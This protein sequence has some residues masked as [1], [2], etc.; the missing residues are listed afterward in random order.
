MIS[1]AYTWNQALESRT[2]VDGN[3]VDYNYVL[4][5]Y[6]DETLIVVV[7]GGSNDY[8][9]PTP[10]EFHKSYYEAIHGSWGVYAPGYEQSN[11]GPSGHQSGFGSIG[12][13][14]YDDTVYNQALSKVYDDIRGTIDLSVDFA[15]A[16]QVFRMLKSVS[17]LSNYVRSF[18]PKNWGRKWLEYQYGW[19]PLVNTV[20]ESANRVVNQAV[21]PKTVKARAAQTADLVDSPFILGTN[22]QASRR[23]Y[24]SARAEISLTYE[25]P[26][27]TLNTLSQF[28]SLNPA[29]IAWELMPGSFVI[30]WLVDVGGYLRNAE[31]ALLLS[32]GFKS[33]Y[34]TETTLLSAVTTSRGSTTDE[35]G[36]T[37]Y[38]F[39]DGYAR[40]VKKRRLAL[41]EA[42]FP[43]PPSFRADLGAQRLLSAASLL[44]LHLG[45]K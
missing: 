25:L 43:R 44:S 36:F 6:S 8:S 9:S 17:K 14:S 28:T 35:L 18:S 21:T 15:Q 33:G 10:F 38:C 42:P 40:Q 1:K 7:D 41:S 30:D 3:T 19:R 39:V 23:S 20:Y 12:N 27:S 4:V 29:S 32:T 2:V 11:N 5:P 31:S 22:V 24:L 26:P 37:Q 34:S 45:R 13:G 16:G